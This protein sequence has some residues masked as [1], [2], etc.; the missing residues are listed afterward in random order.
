M[1]S[2]GLKMIIM[3]AGIVLAGS[4]L[5]SAQNLIVNGSFEDG[6][7]CQEYHLPCGP[8]GWVTL[9]VKTKVV[10]Y[11]MDKEKKKQSNHHF[12]MIL[13]NTKN[14]IAG[15]TYVQTMLCQPLV[16]G[17][18]YRLTMRCFTGPAPFEQAGVLLSNDEI[19][20]GIDTLEKLAS[21]FIIRAD[22]VQ[23]KTDLKKWLTVQYTFTAAGG[24]QFLTL[25]NFSKTYSPRKTEYTHDMFGD[26]VFSFDDI[27]LAPEKEGLADIDTSCAALKKRLY[28]QH[29]RHTPY[30][31]LLGEPKKAVTAPPAPLSKPTPVNP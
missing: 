9:P 7:T 10:F 20:D 15:R 17:Q 24:E 27:Y 18:R 3:V 31:Y 8:A 12:G 29:L 2:L 19:I 6:N 25:G 26:I 28:D 21:T 23:D 11:G 30:V 16:A 1:M 22:S 5:C 4:S 13:E 14:P